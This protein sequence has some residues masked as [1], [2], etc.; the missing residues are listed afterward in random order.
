MAAETSN[1]ITALPAPNSD[2]LLLVD[3]R[4]LITQ[5]CKSPDE[6]ERLI[7][8]YARKVGFKHVRCTGDFT[9]RGTG[10]SATK[11][12]AL[13]LRSILIIAG[14]G[15]SGCRRIRPVRTCSGRK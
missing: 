1:P 13:L 2:E 4:D 12:L 8:E 14:F 10:A 15:T 6:A 9:T 7:I 5:A 3:V 11:D